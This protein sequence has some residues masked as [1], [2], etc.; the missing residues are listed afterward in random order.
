MEGS[1][2]LDSNYY[3]NKKKRVFKEPTGDGDFSILEKKQFSAESKKKMKWA[4]NMYSDWRKSR[5]GFVGCPDEIIKAN[6][7]LL[8]TFDKRDLCY[9]L[10]K[11]VTEIK[12]LDGKE[13]PPN[14]IREIVICIQMHLHENMIVWKLLDHPEFLSLHNVY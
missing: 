4:V 2:D 12:R 8:H 13:Y 14:T 3:A 1:D 9:A 5:I 6:L 10:S 11:F 7:D